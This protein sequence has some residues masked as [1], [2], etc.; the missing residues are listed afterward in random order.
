MPA[1]VPPPPPAFREVLARRGVDASLLGSLG[2][3]CS[4]ER[5]RRLDA[6]GRLVP[7]DLSP[8]DLDVLL[9]ERLLDAQGPR[10][11][12]RLR[13]VQLA[14]TLKPESPSAT[15]NS[16][17][18]G[19]VAPAAAA[20]IAAP[21]KQ[22]VRA[23]AATDGNP[24]PS[25]ETLQAAA[26]ALYDGDPKAAVAL[27]RQLALAAALPAEEKPAFARAIDDP[28]VVYVALGRTRVPHSEDAQLYFR[29]MTQLLDARGRTLTGFI[30][31]VDPKA[32]YA[33]FFLLRAHSYDALLPY[34][35]RRPDE[36]G[37]IVDFLFP[38]KPAE[39]RAH[40]AQLEGLL[41][42]LAARG[43]ASGA[44]E[45]FVDRLQ[46]R[47]ELAPPRAAARIALYL[48]LNEGLLPKALRPQADALSRFLP[49][50]FLDEAGLAPPSP[51]ELWPSDRWTFA[52]HFASTGAFTTWIDR[53]EERGYRVVE[54]DAARA[55]L[56][57]DFDGREVRLI[58]RLHPGDEQ[59]FLRGTQARGFLSAVA[60]ELRDPGIQGV[61][62]RNHAQFS[63]LALIDART[64][65]GKLLLDGSCRSAWD[66]QALRRRCPTCSFVVNTGT[67][68]G[69]I[70]NAAV[71]AVIEGLARGDD[72]S[73][74]AAQWQR[75]MPRDASRM[76][77]PWTPAYD[78]ALAALDARER[79]NDLYS[80]KPGTD[81][82][83]G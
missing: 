3:S 11:E 48:K 75:V 53:F 37:E 35:N 27:R 56:S 24:Q 77:G 40:A 18:D 25:A 78:E 74:I 7:P 17:Y 36:A 32:R 28:L 46:A 13:P 38:D 59:G 20:V 72:W 81:R 9:A 79:K 80:A 65:A 58:G 63:A 39:L 68:F 8:D 5:C 52:L 34:L 55:V 10:R 16:L 64:T 57:R 26:R 73:Q 47:A 21:P 19:Q 82:A 31:E 33:A 67:G 69:R 42:Q 1:A 70:N 43:R 60:R 29:R 12:E 49:P 62:L 54:R 23:A 22:A 41:T 76:Q 51:A 6:H 30:S 4:S 71:A 14:L 83:G 66:L 15:L 50:G 2:L 44:L 61:I 45:S